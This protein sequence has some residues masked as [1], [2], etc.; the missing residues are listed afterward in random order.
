MAQTAYVSLRR[1]KLVS[2][3]QDGAPAA[4]SLHTWV[5]WDNLLMWLRLDTFYNRVTS[6]CDAV[7]SVINGGVYKDL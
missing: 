4:G 5:A 7:T 3:V 2:V 6:I 1:S